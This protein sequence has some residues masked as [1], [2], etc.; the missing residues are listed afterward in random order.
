[1]VHGVV[2]YGMP[3]VYHFNCFFR[4]LLYVVAN[5]EE[6]RFYAIVV[7]QVEY[8]WCNFGYRPIVEGQIY[9]LPFPFYAK[10]RFGE[11]KSE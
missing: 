7:K 9:T 2:T 8:P 10:Q 1:M 6:C 5:H 3:S 11:E 4:M